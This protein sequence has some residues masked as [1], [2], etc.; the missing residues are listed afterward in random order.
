[1]PALTPSPCKVHTFGRDH[2]SPFRAGLQWLKALLLQILGWA[3]L[4]QTGRRDTPWAQLTWWPAASTLF[5]VAFIGFLPSLLKSGVWKIISPSHKYTGDPSPKQDN[6]DPSSWV[7]VVTNEILMYK[8]LKEGFH[9]G[10]WMWYFMNS[11]VFLSGS[12]LSPAPALLCV[13]V[14]PITLQL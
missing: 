14:A 13:T 3:Q 10:F 9:L 2:W 4:F 12:F 6:V 1:M 8:L 5:A 11:T 7:I